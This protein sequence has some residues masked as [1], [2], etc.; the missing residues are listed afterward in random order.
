MKIKWLAAIAALLLCVPALAAGTPRLEVKVPEQ[1]AKPEE[2]I[3]VELELHDAPKIAALGFHIQYDKTRL[4]L[5]GYEDAGLTGWVVGLGQGESAVWVNEK[6]WSGDGSCLTLRFRV[7][8][9]AASGTASIGITDLEAYN[10]REEAVALAVT[11][12]GLLVQGVPGS[13]DNTD[14]TG[15]ADADNST[16]TPGGSQGGS[17]SPAD[18]DPAGST[19][20]TGQTP[21]EGITAPSGGGEQPGTQPAGEAPI[22]TAEKGTNPAAII[23]IAAAAAACVI[24]L[25]CRRKIQHLHNKQ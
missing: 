23:I 1:H 7:R 2:E 15:N 13:A 12:G 8:Q 11:P 14:N 9:D 6:G 25:L 17:L 24:Y 19:A 10:I 20:P 4:E 5:T 21:P 22:P 18:G 16:G 3:T